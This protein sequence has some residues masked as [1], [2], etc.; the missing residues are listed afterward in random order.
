MAPTDVFVHFF[1]I[2]ASGF[3]TLAEGQNVQFEV[4]RG[5]KGLVERRNVCEGRDRLR[6]R[7]TV[8][9]LEA[10][11]SAL[12]RLDAQRSPHVLCQVYNLIN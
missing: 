8:D 7:P 6:T 12:W 5:P 3:R 2:N 10:L 1:A 11:F 9:W 4:E